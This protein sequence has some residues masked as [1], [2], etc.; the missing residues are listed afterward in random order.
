[1]PEHILPVAQYVLDCLG[2]EFPWWE[3][4]NQG[5]CG[6]KGG[7][8]LLW[9]AAE[10]GCGAGGGSE[11]SVS[12]PGAAGVGCGA[13]G[14]SESCVPI[15]CSSEQVSGAQEQCVRECENKDKLHLG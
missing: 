1:M 11:G 5:R 2:L 7:S 15:L 8:E 14:G 13:G 12:I 10:V 9:A 4:G 3:F 6:A